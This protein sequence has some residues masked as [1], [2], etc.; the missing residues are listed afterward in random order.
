MAVRSKNP[1]VS[2]TL[3]A[4]VSISFVLIIAGLALAISRPIG[5]SVST[6][7]PSDLVKAI[8]DG[9]P[10][11]LITAGI[12]VLMLTPFAR[13]LVLLDEFARARE[14][15]FVVISIVVLCLLITSIA[16][17]MY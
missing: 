13:V 7:P 2:A 10:A 6:P 11:S 15:S 3:I 14:S 12:F 1:L 16:I 17:G 4:G 9:D 8:S 5:L